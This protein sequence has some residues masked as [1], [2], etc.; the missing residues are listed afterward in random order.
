[1]QQNDE[2]VVTLLLALHYHSYLEVKCIYVLYFTLQYSTVQYSTQ[3]STIHLCTVL[4]SAI[5]Y[6][7]V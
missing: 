4:Y 5:Q 1:M 7:T 6:S 2:D 3:Y